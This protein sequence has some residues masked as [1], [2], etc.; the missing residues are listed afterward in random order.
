MSK[1]LSIT[2]PTFNR[3]EEL[4]RQL[5]WLANELKGFE[6]ECDILISDNCS[7][8]DTPAVVAKWRSILSGVSFRSIRNPENIGC[9]PNL[10]Q[11]LRYAT[12]QFVWTIGDDDLIRPG[13]LAFV[14]KTIQEKNKD[15]ALL[16]LNFSGLEKETGEVGGERWFA[17][18]L[19]TDAPNGK[20]AFSQHFENSLGAVVFITSA[21]YR[22]QFVQESLVQ[23][24]ESIE[25]WGA[26]AYWA[27]YCAAK[28]RLVVTEENFVQCL[29][30]QS[31]WAKEKGVYSKIPCRDLP[32]VCKQLQKVGYSDNACR[33]IVSKYFNE[34]V[35]QGGLRFFA[36]AFK[37][38]PIATASTIVFVMGATGGF[39]PETFVRRTVE[40]SPIELN[41]KS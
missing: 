7:T 13:T 22:T 35:E 38:W 33:R 39:V 14:L 36:Q 6:Q 15:L 12:G 34:A 37:Y 10:A 21:I 41:E 9:I 20:P 25:N 27:G 24:P 16:Y 11:C 32:E 26:M 19:P 30:G 40:P 23:W 1:L 4:D 8:D 28:G 18:E 17:P 3:A 29:L 5:S 31:H 2:I